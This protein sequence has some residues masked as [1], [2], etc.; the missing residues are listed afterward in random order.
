LVIKKRYTQDRKLVFVVDSDLADKSAA[1]YETYKNK[2]KIKSLGFRWDKEI[3]KWVS[4]Q[5]YEPEE[6]IVA[7]PQIRQKLNQLNKIKM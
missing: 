2:Q 7:L 6:L 5:Q 1:G 4:V 3:S